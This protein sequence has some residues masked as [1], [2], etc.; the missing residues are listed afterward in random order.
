MWQLVRE[1]WDVGNWRAKDGL[2]EPGEGCVY[3]DCFEIE[4][5]GDG[6]LQGGQWWINGGLDVL[7]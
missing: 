4:M 6:S 3:S 7:S 1:R 5:S 2:K